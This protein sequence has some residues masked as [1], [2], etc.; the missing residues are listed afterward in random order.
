MS[1]K[2]K[3]IKYLS[4]GLSPQVMFLY[5]GNFLPAKFCGF[6]STKI[7]SET[8]LGF[9][10]SGVL[11]DGNCFHTGMFK[12]CLKKL[13]TLDHEIHPYMISA[14]DIISKRDFQF[15]PEGLILTLV[16]QSYDIFELGKDIPE[17]IIWI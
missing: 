4:S 2:E 10:F 14:N 17:Y 3:I 13:K 16:Q 5:R 7:T 1:V 11:P 9:V 8:P 12:L 6:Q 15:W